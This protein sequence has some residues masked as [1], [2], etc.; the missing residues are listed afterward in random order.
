M[1]LATKE[2]VFELSEMNTGLNQIWVEAS[3]AKKKDVLY[4]KGKDLMLVFDGHGYRVRNLAIIL[5]DGTK[6]KAHV[7]CEYTPPMTW[8]E[9]SYLIRK[10]AQIYFKGFTNEEGM[11]MRTANQMTLNEQDYRDDE[12]YCQ[13]VMKPFIS[14]DA[15][16]FSG[17]YPSKMFLKGLDAVKDKTSVNFVRTPARFEAGGEF[18][19]NRAMCNAEQPRNIKDGYFIELRKPDISNRKTHINDIWKPNQPV[20]KC[21]G[22]S[23]STAIRTVPNKP[24]EGMETMSDARRAPMYCQVRFTNTRY[25]PCPDGW[26]SFK[27]PSGMKWC[28]LHHHTTDMNE[29]DSKQFCKN[30]GAFLDGYENADEYAVMKSQF[31]RLKGCFNMIRILEMVHQKVTKFKWETRINGKCWRNRL[32]GHRRK[33]CTTGIWDQKPGQTKQNPQINGYKYGYHPAP[34]NICSR[35]NVFQWENNVASEPPSIVDDNWNVEHDNFPNP[36]YRRRGRD[37]QCLE[38]LSD[39]DMNDFGLASSVFW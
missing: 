27:R 4:R 12:K 29:A 38:L 3:D 6:D 9:S 37:E 25:G 34:E 31:E 10:Y 39:G 11:F 33:E 17:A 24:V 28:H 19:R 26:V 22:G 36:S 20:L 1:G 8:E 2:Q 15:N 16:R 5:V 14:P 18:R 35:R 32:G 13:N 21:D 23:W 7:L 30:E